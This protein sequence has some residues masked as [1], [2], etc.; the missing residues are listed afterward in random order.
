MRRRASNEVPT[1]MKILNTVTAYIRV[2]VMFPNCKQVF[3]KLTIADTICSVYNHSFKCHRND[4]S[5]DV[6]FLT[7]SLSFVCTK[8]EIASYLIFVIIMSTS[9][10]FIKARS[11]C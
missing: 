9:G 4:F 5:F 1:K 3:A 8:N 2:D 7:S 11:V 10:L 6:A